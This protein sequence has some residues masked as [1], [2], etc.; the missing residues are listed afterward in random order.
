MN[1]YPAYIRRGDDPSDEDS[2]E[3]DRQRARKWY[4]YNNRLE[5]LLKFNNEESPQW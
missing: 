5:R 4:R 1:N 3:F 2:L